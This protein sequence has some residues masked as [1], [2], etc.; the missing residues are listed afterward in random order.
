MNCRNIF[1]HA[2]MFPVGK[3]AYWEHLGF[4]CFDLDWA[5]VVCFLSWLIYFLS[6]MVQCKARFC[7]KTRLGELEAALTS[8]AQDSVVGKEASLNMTSLSNASYDIEDWMRVDDCSRSAEHIREKWG[9][10]EGKR[11]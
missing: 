8:T 2:S 4:E 9:L 11:Q 7:A 1:S 10:F 6:W 5:H 3:F